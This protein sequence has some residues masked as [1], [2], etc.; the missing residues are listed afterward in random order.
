MSSML[1]LRLG[2]APLLA[3]VLALLLTFGAA[4]PA[5]ADD[6][7]T[8]REHYQKGTSFYDL[9]RY[10]EA[11]K[12]FEAAYEIKNDPALLYNLAQ[13][14]RLAGNSEQALHFYRTYLRY[15]PNAKNRA[16]IEDRIKQLEQLVAQ[17]NATQTAPPNQTIPPPGTTTPP[18]TTPPATTTPPETTPVT[19]PPPSPPPTTVPE[20]TPLPP[21][22]PLGLSTQLPAAAPP[23]DHHRMIR[24]GEITVAA[25][26][27]AFILGAAF[28]SFA[29]G[30][31][32]EV[33]NAAKNGGTFDPSVEQRGKNYQTAEAVFMTLG[34]LT[35]G[36][37]AVLFFYGNHLAKQERMT[38][39]PIATTSGGGASLRVTF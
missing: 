37:G 7:A 9:G 25:G 12:E 35:A 26:V 31:A 39:T 5:R 24:A 4:K 14:H 28:G 8:A 16:E 21:Q 17:K 13:S 23:N 36:T 10:A 33:N 3:P 6:A 11:I 22:G 27:G 30:A 15:V 2:F 38:V 1:R 32:N 29:K 19:T 20:V 18:A 34:A